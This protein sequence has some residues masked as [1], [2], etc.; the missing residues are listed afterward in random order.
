MCDRSLGGVCDTPLLCRARSARAKG[1]P[2]AFGVI[3]VWLIDSA[4]N[5]SPSPFRSSL[6]Q[7]SPRDGWHKLCKLKFA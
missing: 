3:A 7:G 1:S 2:S 6:E 4:V 5:I